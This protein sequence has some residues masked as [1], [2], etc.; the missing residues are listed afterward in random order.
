V[1]TEVRR[2]AGPLLGAVVGVIAFESGF[3]LELAS[4]ERVRWLMVGNDTTIHFLGWH[5]FRHRPWTFPLGANPALQY[6]VG[7][8]VA[9]SDSIPVM[10]ITFKVLDPLLP[11][12]FQ[13][14]GLWMLSCFA[15]Q[16]ALGA[17]LSKILTPSLTLQGLTAALF[18]LAPAFVY[19]LSI[20]HAALA[21]HW[22][23][24][25]AL[26]VYFR[27]RGEKSEKRQFTEAAVIAAIAAGTHAYLAFMVFAVL[28]AFYGRRALERPSRA[29]ASALAPFLLVLLVG[30]IV[31]WQSGYLVVG[32]AEVQRVGFGWYSLNLLA[33]LMPMGTSA[34]LSTEPFIVS[35]IGQYEGYAYLGGGMVLLALVAGLTL[36]ARRSPVSTENRPSFAAGDRLRGAHDA[37]VEPARRS[38]LKN[39][40]RVSRID[41]GTRKRLPRQRPHVLARLLRDD[42]RHCRGHHQKVYC[43]ARNPALVGGRVPT[44]H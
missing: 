40:V 22:L 17:A 43:T 4:P 1:N 28:A 41:L 30:A 36:L 20:G 26:W 10:A 7:T 3:G 33:P 14:I 25:A 6:P 11:R 16:G 5:L 13:Y 44:S 38:R 24:V 9:L 32:G 2:F 12:D 42:I 19:R 31:F 27:E 29:L 34:L 21:A 37:C 39:A 18:V 8:S 23:V 15:L 35:T